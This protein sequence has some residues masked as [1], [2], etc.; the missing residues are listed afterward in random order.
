MVIAKCFF[1]SCTFYRDLLL[2]FL[3]ALLLRYTYNLA[4][5]DLT[6]SVAFRSPPHA[7]AF[8]TRPHQ[9]P[10]ISPFLSTTRLKNTLPFRFFFLRTVLPSGVA[11]V[12][13]FSSLS[14]V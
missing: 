2:A 9:H 14:S 6:R 13:V 10:N 3:S 7:H 1:L 11:V 5:L 4:V 8:F 12:T